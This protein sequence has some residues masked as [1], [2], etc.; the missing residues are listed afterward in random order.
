MSHLGQEQAREQAVRKA[1][2]AADQIILE[3]SNGSSE[4]TNFLTAEVAY[5]FAEKVRL[6]IR[7]Q[8]MAREIRRKD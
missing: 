4:E 1:V 5:A 2:A 7:H 8:L 6:A 3:T